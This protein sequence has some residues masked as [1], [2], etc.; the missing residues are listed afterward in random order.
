MASPCS[1][2][3]A[4]TH[5]PR[6][7]LPLRAQPLKSPQGIKIRPQETPGG[8]CLLWVTCQCPSPVPLQSCLPEA[9]AH[10]GAP[11]ESPKTK[12]QQLSGQGKVCQR[13]QGSPRLAWWWERGRPEAWREKSRKREGANLAGKGRGCA[14]STGDWCREQR[15]GYRAEGRG[16]IK[17]CR[18]RSSSLYSAGTGG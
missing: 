16:G 14:S 13:P 5:K 10:S 11:G 17:R 4:D 9:Q 18:H 1:S 2:G 6:L 7:S 12:A 8:C 3:D 15:P